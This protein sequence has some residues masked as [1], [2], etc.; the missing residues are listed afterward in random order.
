M[1]ISRPNDPVDPLSPRVA[2]I[3]KNKSAIVLEPRDGMAT[4]FGPVGCATYRW[5]AQGDWINTQHFE[6]FDEFKGLVTDTRK[7]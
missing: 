4:P 7:C 3:D 2:L 6:S 1:R 5:S